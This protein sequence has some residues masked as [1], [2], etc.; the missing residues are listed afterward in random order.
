MLGNLQVR[1]GGGMLEKDGN[2]P[3]QHPTL[4]VR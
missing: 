4:P 3:R 2:V 1:F